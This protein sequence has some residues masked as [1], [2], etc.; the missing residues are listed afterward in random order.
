MYELWGGSPFRRCPKTGHVQDRN[1]ER[2]RLI[3][4]SA[5]I[6]EML[7]A[8]IGGQGRGGSASDEEEEDEAGDEDDLLLHPAGWKETEVAYVS[9]TEH[10]DW[11]ADCLRTFT[12]P[13]LLEDGTGG[14]KQQQRP[15]DAARARRRRER[16]ASPS[17]SVPHLH[18]LAAHHE[19]Y[20]GSKV[21]HFRRLRER[22]GLEYDQMLF[23]DNERWNIT[24]VERLGVVCCYCPRGL[25]RE[26][27]AEGL[28]RYEERALAARP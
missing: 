25:T 20:P 18:A 15:R 14:G 23:F 17:S 21:T 19:I 27:W 1:G 11:A 7:A 28:R 22:T 6:L 2:V 13:L 4:E 16:R 10:A 12:F 3:G 5:R 24:A 26:A 9:R 8:A